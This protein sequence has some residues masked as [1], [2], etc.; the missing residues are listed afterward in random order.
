M[1]SIDTTAP[2]GELVARDPR[3]GTLFEQ[4]GI[5]YCCGGR[6]TLAEACVRRGLDADTV[7]VLLA[8]LRGTR[9]AETDE[10][11]DVAQSTIAELC[12]HIVTAHHDRL[13]SEL[14]RISELIATVARVHG[15]DHPEL[16]DLQRVFEAMRSG[17]ELHLELEERELFPRCRRLDAGRAPDEEVD[18]SLLALLEDEH[19]ATG[20]ALLAL[21]ELAG[22]YRRDR[23]LCGTH[24]RLLDGLHALERDIHQHVH[25]ENN[26][27]FGKVRDRLVPAA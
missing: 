17:L 18:E 22:G 27:L 19:D 15:A 21:R 1:T 16:A 24:R 23:A 8:G 26:L 7:A 4:L 12:E 25:E 6:R 3:A 14:P 9:D 2:V 5:D 10:E 11:H 13:R 20:D